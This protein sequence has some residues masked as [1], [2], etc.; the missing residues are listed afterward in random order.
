MDET[1]KSDFSKI[2]AKQWQED[3][4]KDQ[5]A[6]LEEEK[7][8]MRREIQALQSALAERDKQLQELHAAATREVDAR[9]T[10][11]KNLEQTLQSK[12]DMIASI[13]RD[14]NMLRTA[15]E[16]ERAKS[17]GQFISGK[18]KKK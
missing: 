2:V 5:I 4:L 10:H 7:E 1:P 16:E 9:N 13:K 14:S 11:I 15:L 17:L 3:Q 8:K 12:E 6:K 18:F